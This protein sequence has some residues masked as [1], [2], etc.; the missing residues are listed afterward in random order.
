MIKKFPPEHKQFEK[1]LQ[2]LDKHEISYETL[3]GYN[4]NFDMKFLGALMK[5]NNMKYTNYFNYYEIDVYGFVKYL[6]LPTK[7]K[8]L[9]TVC[10]FFK[11]KLDNAHDALA[12]IKATRELY[13]KMNKL[14][15]K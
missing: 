3:A 9:S 6:E 2:F 15:L 13:V 12:D 10:D 14:Y 5:R 11:V 1:L 7:N 8:Q 4:V